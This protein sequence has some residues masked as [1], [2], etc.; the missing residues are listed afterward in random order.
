MKEFFLTLF[1]LL[2]VSPFALAAG[3]G[4]GIPWAIVVKQVINLSL[5]VGLMFWF[6]KDKVKS[7]FRNK[8]DDY[9]KQKEESLKFIKDAESKFHDIKQ[10]LENL[11]STRESGCS[12]I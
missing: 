9:K 3:G 11:R 4:E 7:Y 12:A 10:A 5:F 6:L 1:I 8:A 2:F